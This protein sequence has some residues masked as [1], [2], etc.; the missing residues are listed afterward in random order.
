MAEDGGVLTIRFDRP[1]ALNALT[2]PMVE[3]TS[4]LLEEASAR[5]EVRVVLLTGTGGAFSTGADI[6]GGD[7]HERFDVGALDAANRLV[8]AIL[9]CDSPVVAGV[10]G[11]A[12]G[13][14]FSA[15]LA[16][17]L[18]VCTESA[19]LLLAF[20]RIGLMPDGGATATV[21][22]SA[23]RARALRMALLAEPLS[24]RAAHESGLVSHV[25]A[26]PDYEGE[27]AGVVRTLRRGAPLAHAAI[28]RAVNAAALAHV[29]RQ[30][31]DL[32]AGGIL[33]PADTNRGVQA[34]RVCEH[35]TLSHGSPSGIVFTAILPA[36]VG[37]NFGV[38]WW[39][40]CVR[41]ARPAAPFGRAAGSRPRPR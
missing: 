26:D 12:A 3:E 23:G 31:D 8:R 39:C 22:A 5:E 6:S 19:T 16:C 21:A 40:A 10:N 11:V 37:G 29:D 1:E 13:V 38:S 34:T 17:D 36:V 24:A 14:G 4:R 27:L 28:K 33:Q 32:F 9:R 18:A 30:R 2:G 15:V 25:A 20:A 41:A 35:Y 7:A